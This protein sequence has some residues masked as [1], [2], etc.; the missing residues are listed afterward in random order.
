MSTE[1]NL[2]VN[3]DEWTPNQKTAIIRKLFAESVGL[4]ELSAEK[5]IGLLPFEA[6]MIRAGALQT[7][8]I[9]PYALFKPQRFIIFEPIIGRHTPKTIIDYRTA[10]R[11]ALWWKKEVQEVSRRVD[12]EDYTEH[13]IPRSSFSLV[14]GFVGQQAIWPA[15][16]AQPGDAFGIENAL[17]FDAPVCQE[18]LTITIQVR[19]NTDKA[20]PFSAAMIGKYIA[21]E[22]KLPEPE[23]V[24]TSAS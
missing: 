20:L 6:P 4:I 22:R 11:G 14:G 21:K 18:G 16:A 5:G 2:P 15:M 24:E 12:V 10:T 17:P 13:K 19:N 8:Q 1:E 7:V 3:T 23:S 9:T